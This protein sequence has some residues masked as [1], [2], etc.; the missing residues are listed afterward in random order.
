MAEDRSSGRA[1]PHV[2]PRER[3][4]LGVGLSEKS[5]TA[6]SPIVVVKP[7]RERTVLGVGPSAPRPFPAP[8][9]REISIQEPPPEEGWD[10][11]EEVRASVAAPSDR[12]LAPEV[13]RSERSLVPAGVPRHRGRWLVIFLIL[14]LGVSFGY[15]RR[16]R[17]RP[18][19][20]RV[21]ER[22]GVVKG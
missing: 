1:A 20:E 13:L 10:V 8:P 3:T 5:T 18:V 9:S 19:L 16:D 7:T 21:L 12:S 14:A 6:P 4:T 15:V 17:L 22:V 11:P 2:P